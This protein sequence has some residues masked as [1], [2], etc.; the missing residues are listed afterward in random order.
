MSDVVIVVG[1]K[2]GKEDVAVLEIKQM[3]GRAGRKHGGFTAKA[4]VVVEDER[5]VEVRE[6]LDQ[7]ANMDVKSPFGLGDGL[8]FHIMPEISARRVQD[9]VSAVK[10]YT[11][12]LGAFQG[13]KVKFE[14]IFDK[15]VV[16]GAII[17]VGDQIRSTPIGEIASDLYFHPGDVQSWKDNFSKVFE[18]GLE[19]DTAAIAWALGTRYHSNSQGDFGEQRFVID[20][21]KSDLPFG[22]DAKSGA[23]IQPVLWWCCMGGPPAGKMRNVMLSLREDIGRIRKALDRIDEDVMHWGKRSF[24]SDVEL[25]VRKGIGINF[26]DLC[27]LPGITKSR[28]DFLYNRGVKDLA[29][30]ADIID[31]IEDE[32]DEP[33]LNLLKEL[34]HGIPRKSS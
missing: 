25:M 15:M 10:W 19:N 24:F 9:E 26:L 28:A 4:Y 20:D 12:S 3:I 14:R 21:F 17:R 18:M 16:E 2:R 33:F 6:G 29:G 5:I 30:I 34:I 1:T 22:L 31:N 11:R 13:R 8:F 32:I 27:K 23:T 7:G